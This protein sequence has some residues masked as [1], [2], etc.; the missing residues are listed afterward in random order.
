MFVLMIF[1]TLLGMSDPEV[2]GVEVEEV[3]S[4]YKPPPEKT[5]EEILSADKEDESLQKYKELLLGEAK[6][7]KVIVG[8]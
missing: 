3:E 1:D 6:E 4:S 7:G 8:K 2:V 5:L